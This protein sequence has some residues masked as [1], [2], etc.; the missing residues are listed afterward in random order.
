MLL[1]SGL[2]FTGHVPL[3]DA[4]SN[5]HI[6]VVTVLL[7]LNA[8]ANPRTVNDE[9][10]ADLAQFNG[11]LQCEKMLREYVPPAPRSKRD[12]W[13]HGTL[14]RCEA[15]EILRNCKEQDGVYLVRYS[16]RHRGEVLTI[17]HRGQLF[18]YMIR[19]EVRFHICLQSSLLKIVFRFNVFLIFLQNGYY[20]IDSGPFH[21]TLE[22]VID[23]Y[24]LLSDGLPTTLQ[25]PVP[26]KPKPKLPE[27]PAHGVTF[28]YFCMLLVVCM[29]FS[30]TDK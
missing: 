2:E 14:D 27:I 5:G 26:P 17:Y 19:K 20:F 29:N 21:N 6:D 28:S 8:P 13:H 3:H 7:S 9:T 10:P 30:S 4:A 24:T 11:F 15:E 22:H 1:L 25:F 18:N 12:A 23:Y 16:K